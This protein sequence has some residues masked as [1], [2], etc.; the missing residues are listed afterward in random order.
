MALDYWF[1]G[2]MRRY[3]VQFCRIFEGFTYQ[4]GVGANGA[5]VFRTFPVKLASKDRQIGHLLRNNSENVAMSTPRLS[6]D[7]T[8]IQMAPERRQDPSLVRS[9]GITERAL[10]PITQLYTGERGRSYTVERYMAVP[11]DIEMEVDIWVSNESQKHQF[12]EQVLMLFNP[13]I[14]LQTGTN[15]VDWTSL[16]IVELTGINWSSRSFP[17]MD[18][19]IEVS[20]LKFK[21]PIWIS[22]PAK[23]K[24]QNIIH[25]IITNITA[26]PT[27]T[28]PDQVEGI[29]FSQSDL[30]T[31]VISTPH[32]HQIRVDGDEITLLDASGV[33]NPDL[34]WI[35][36]LNLYGQFRP[37]V[38]QIR[39]KT[40]QNMDDHSSDIIGTYDLHPTDSTKILWTSDV[41]TLPANTLAAITAMIDMQ[42]RAPGRGGLVT[43]TAGQRYLLAEDL[44]LSDNGANEW[45]NLSADIN[46]IIEYNGTA[47]FKAFDASAVTQE[48]WLVNLRSGDQL[49]WTGEMWVKS[50]DGEYHAGFW[51]IFL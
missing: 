8:D 39:L 24:R 44:V 47:W 28:T 14:D 13:A 15:P 6:I 12:M 41:E 49:R 45:S 26:V 22:P 42:G 27:G 50:V 48:Q 21:M 18:S 31:R 23:I 37:G 46:D 51:R 3:W 7:M 40:T 11:Y 36:L 9:I 4:T 16:T 29:E 33:D 19:E 2:Q 43:A 5:T 1:D 30:H 10:D 38:S 17:L 25:Q 20:T 35:N 32:N 34:S